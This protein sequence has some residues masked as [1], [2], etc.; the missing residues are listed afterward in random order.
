MILKKFHIIGFIF[1]AILGTVLHFVYEWSGD[2]QLFGVLGAANES[3]WEHAKLLAVPM[4]LYGVAEYFFYGKRLD[5]F[6]PM[7]FLSILLGMAVIIAGY[8]TYTGILGTGYMAADIVLFY[9]AVL[10]AYS[11]GAS[12]MKSHALSSPAAN[13]IAL[14]GVLLLIFCLVRFS[15]D[16]PKI[17]LFRDSVTGNYGMGNSVI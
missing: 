16:P 6:I 11:F 9:L 7:R 1:T 15:F 3:V 14:V 13:W 10:A 2:V 17:P 4:L 8:Y 5:N 12:M